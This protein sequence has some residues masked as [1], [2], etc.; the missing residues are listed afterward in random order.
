MLWL[1][2]LNKTKKFYE[3]HICANIIF[4]NVIRE[5]IIKNDERNLSRQKNKKIKA[6]EV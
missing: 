5:K 2:N 3:K 1:S 4:K 6:I